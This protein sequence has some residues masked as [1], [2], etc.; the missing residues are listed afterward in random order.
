VLRRLLG[1]FLVLVAVFYII[2]NPVG[3][4]GTAQTVGAAMGDAL[5]ALLTFFRG[6]AD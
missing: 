4:A 6:L 1:W 3:A 2:T 5:E